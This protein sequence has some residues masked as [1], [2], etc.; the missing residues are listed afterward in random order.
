MVPVPQAAPEGALD[1]ER[2]PAPG[3]RAVVTPLAAVGPSRSAAKTAT[4]PPLDP[5]AA[6]PS[7]PP[8]P[9]GWRR[10]WSCPAEMALG[11]RFQGPYCIDRWEAALVEIGRDGSRRPWP[12]NRDVDGR[13]RY[14]AAVSEPGRKP[15]GYVSGEQAVKLC[16]AAGKYLCE[17]DQWV[18]A[19]RGRERRRYPYGNE[20]R[21]G[22]CNDR[23]KVL[24]HHPVPTLWKRDGKPPG[25]V[26]MWHPEFMNDA[27]LFDLPHTVAPSGSFAQCTGDVGTFDQ[28]GNLH[29]WVRDA[30]GT[31]M[32]GFF[33]DTF[34]NGEGCE[35]RTIGHGFE[36]HDYSIGFRCC[37]D[38]SG[39]D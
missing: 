5:S 3:D 24:D 22:V 15:Q 28:V 23:F 19:C 18:T 21:A 27:R 4:E 9:Q 10:A 8:D 13:E 31:F 34:Q 30:D 11:S 16:A 39:A 29:E 25:D 36:Y 38:A 7:A 6:A 33:M 1:R 17:P 2:T 14:F 37:A 20:R 26:L 35:Y 32:G 12:P